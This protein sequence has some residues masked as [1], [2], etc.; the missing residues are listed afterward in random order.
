[1]EVS[2]T[3][4]EERLFSE[5]LGDSR[6][7]PLGPILDARAHRLID[8][9]NFIEI[10]IIQ[11]LCTEDVTLVTGNTGQ[12][13][14]YKGMDEVNEFYESYIGVFRIIIAIADR[15]R[16]I[17]PVRHFLGAVNDSHTQQLMVIILDVDDACKIKRIKM[18]PIGEM[19]HKAGSMWEEIGHHHEIRADNG[20]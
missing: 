5:L 1:M 2:K 17:C 18:R 4:Q 10:E 19:E 9:F 12:E 7:K 14:V 8:S 11:E 6:Y 13:T 15:R 20:L 16:V 3:E